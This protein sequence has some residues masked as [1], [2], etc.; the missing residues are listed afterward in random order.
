MISLHFGVLLVAPIQYFKSVRYDFEVTVS[1]VE[2]SQISVVELFLLLLICL[3]VCLV[4]V[5]SLKFLLNFNLGIKVPDDVLDFL[6][7]C[8]SFFQNFT[9]RW[10]FCGRGVFVVRQL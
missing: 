8:L 7:L 3:L 9:Y 5:Q 1:L 10:W 6:L 4:C 2:Q